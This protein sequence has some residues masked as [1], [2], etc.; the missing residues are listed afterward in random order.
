MIFD[1]GHLIEHWGYSAIFATVILGNVG[2]PLPEES[3]LILAGYLIWARKLRLYSVLILGV[4]A[5]IIGDNLGYWFGRRYGQVAIQRYG[6]RI[7]ITQA[8]LEKAKQFVMRFGFYGVFIARFLPGLR[9]MAGPL[10][11]SV[12]LPFLRF[13]MANLFGALVYVPLCVAT[14]YLLG[15]SLGDAV[16]E[17]EILIG[18]VEHLALVLMGFAAIVIIIWRRHSS[19]KAQ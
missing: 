3:I 19:R 15:A 7:S 4:L 16:K 17:I 9:F 1:A 12:E 10:A 8:K 5:A 6:H 14:G 11:G 13:F 18:R 2:L